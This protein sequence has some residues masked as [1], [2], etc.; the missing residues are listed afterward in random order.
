MTGSAATPTTPFPPSELPG[1]PGLTVLPSPPGTAAPSPGAPWTLEA[2]WEASADQRAG[3]A[4]GGRDVAALASVDVV[5]PVY[6]EEGQL[7]SSILK[8]QAF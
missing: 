8:L 1:R 4:V 6:N 5:I 3:R 7:E 2:A